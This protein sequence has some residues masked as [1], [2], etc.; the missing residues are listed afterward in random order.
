[1]IIEQVIGEGGFA[2]VYE[3]RTAQGEPLAIKVAHEATQAMPTTGLRLLNNEIEAL[4][5][6]RHPSLV[7]THG[8]G[9]LPDG[10]L[11]LVMELVS[12]ATLLRHLE[13]HDRL[14]PT[15]ALSII[16]RVA[17]VM[18]YCHAQG[19]LHLDLKPENIL[20][21]DR[22][23]PSIKVLDFGVARLA[24]AG[25]G[26]LRVI[27]GTVAYM[28]PECF[29]HAELHPSMDVYALG[30]MLYEMLT[31]KLPYGTSGGLETQIRHKIIE[32]PVLDIPSLANTPQ[33]VIDLVRAMLAVDPEA[34][35]PMA[36]LASE[37]QRLYFT[38]L[39]GDGAALSGDGVAKRTMLPSSRPVETTELF[40]RQA[41]LSALCERWAL[42]R[43]SRTCATL[44][45]GSQGTGKST[46]IDHF[47]EHHAEGEPLVAYGRCRESGD[48]LPFG[49]IRE[50]AGHLGE[51][52]RAQ[53]QWHR[54][55]R[56]AREALG[57]L[58]GVIIGLVPE[59]QPEGT[60]PVVEPA[61]RPS[62]EAV[63]RAVLVMLEVV[64]KERPVL[65]VIEDLQW[66]H[67]EVLSVLAAG[68]V[69]SHP[70]VMLLLSSRE[71]PS[72]T[73]QAHVIE[74]GNLEATDNRALLRA[75]LTT[76]DLSVLPRLQQ[77]VPV[78]SS[79]IPMAAASVIADLQ[80]RRCVHRQPDGTVLLDEPRLQAYV[81]PWNVV[82]LLE[83][84][85]T[86]L[87]PV[88]RRVLAAGALC[89]RTFEFEELLGL[90]SLDLFGADDIDRA[91]IDAHALGLLQRDGR[92]CSLAHDVLAERL[93]AE[94]DD[95]TARQLHAAIAEQLRAIAGPPSRLAH[96]LERAG[97][98]S[99]AAGAHRQAA[100][101][102]DA[103]YELADA[104]RHFRRVIELSS[105][106]PDHEHRIELLHE[107]IG[108][109]ARVA[110]ALGIVEEAFAVVRGAAATLA[111]LGIEDD[112]TIDSAFARLHY[113][114][115]EMEP[116]M[117]LS[118]RCLARTED[119]LDLARIR[120]L[121]A[122]LVGRALYMAGRIGE[123]V[124]TLTR[125][126]ELAAAQSESVELCHSL[127]VLGLSLGFMG[128][129][130]EARTHLQQSSQMADELGD[131]VRQVA[132]L[133]YGA[134]GAE[135]MHDWRTGVLRST[136]ALAMVEQQ[137]IDGLYRTLALLCA[138]RHQFHVGHLQR[139]RLL[140]EHAIEC[141]RRQGLIA[142]QR[143]VQPCLGDVSFVKGNFD[144][145]LRT[146]EQ[147]LRETHDD[148]YARAMCLMGCAH[149]WGVT[150]ADPERVHAYA[151]QALDNLEAMDNVAARAH[152]LCRYAD[153]VDALEGPVAALPIAE[154]AR[155]VFERLGIEPVDWWPA[156]P[157]SAHA[158]HG[159]AAYWKSRAYASRPPEP[160]LPSAEPSSSAAV[161]H[162]ITQKMV[163][164]SRIL[165]EE[166]PSA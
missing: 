67:P 55:A 61:T 130:E 107:A 159:P 115:G 105:E 165:E 62:V 116:A 133:C 21:T 85:L 15:E 149:V 90:V 75:L 84:R 93:A 86:R 82:E 24:R 48:L 148:Q 64:A 92:Q 112:A 81:P 26:E 59:A 123:A 104:A 30:V 141:S 98:L 14:D 65:L 89:G 138:G 50:A 129:L 88:V 120:V 46:L 160:E 97:H 117:A 45:L 73:G 44:I 27:A 111:E 158:P 63:T 34:R 66:A 145:A 29:G 39:S 2:C 106:V 164:E 99:R 102:A 56:A 20:I 114:R 122:N 19:V 60:V 16:A 36:L 47:L 4:L 109:Y 150:H 139:A 137:G 18:A 77:Y 94:W 124:A 163:A 68:S 135:C 37:A 25:R 32:P 108:E 43:E 152:A 78:L 132:A 126:C 127:G 162:Q 134:L 22:H 166:R 3:T 96:H 79:G 53:P 23:A 52:L 91:M 140:L 146:Y 80:L 103:L 156:P 153:A 157:E 8:Y 7:K 31:G 6:L 38:A 144:E 119:T 9:F 70:G 58:E 95:T 33:Q 143:W 51:R 13:E 69:R 136:E 57:P 151:Q 11:Y 154:R 100:W 87:D 101:Y 71:P 74:L 76:D 28:A 41:A 131:P 113:L 147:G 142:G 155:R 121:P 12:G 1:M 54:L 35:P 10:R 42:A 49:V 72:W 128:N 17:E 5:R 125:G 161:L 40:G 118:Q 110:G 83:Q